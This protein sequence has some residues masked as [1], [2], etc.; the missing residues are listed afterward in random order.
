MVYS[1]YKKIEYTYTLD[2]YPV[3]ESGRL[4][5]ELEQLQSPL[6]RQKLKENCLDHRPSRRRRMAPHVSANHEAIH[7]PET[8]F[9]TLRLHCET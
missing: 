7:T 4:D 8:T 6:P 5:S 2:E 1:F 3:A 9:C